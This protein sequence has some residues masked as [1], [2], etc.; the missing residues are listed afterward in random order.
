M[1]DYVGSIPSD[2]QDTDPDGTGYE[3]GLSP[4]ND[5]ISVRAPLAE[6]ENEVALN[7][8][9]DCPDG[10]IPVPGNAAYGTEDFCVGQF[11]AKSGGDSLAVGVPATVNG[12]FWALVGCTNNSEENGVPL[13][14]EDWMTIARDIESQPENWISGQV[15]VG[16]MYRGYT[17][18][19]TGSGLAVADTNDPYNGT[20]GS[21]EQRRTY[22]LS[23]GYEIWD[24]SGN[25][26]ETLYD[27]VSGTRPV[28]S[29]GATPVEWTAVSNMGTYSDADFKASNLTWNSAQNIG[30]YIEGPGS[31]FVKGGRRSDTSAAGIYAHMFTS[32][33]PQSDIGYRCKLDAEEA[34]LYK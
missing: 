11:E 31:T 27:F 4:F 21:P 7:I 28:G 1:P 9:I 34:A 22:T 20:S 26:A 8:Y 17:P 32:T 30:Q 15:G 6:L 23:T 19:T 12:G 13:D 5:R 16:S 3:V 33:F 24:F 18:G 14:N 10:Y 29:G 25:V 2:P